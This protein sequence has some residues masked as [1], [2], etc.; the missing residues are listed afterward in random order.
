MEGGG[1]KKQERGEG[2]RWRKKRREQEIEGGRVAGDSGGR[3]GGAR[4][5]GRGR[6][7]TREGGR[8]K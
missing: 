6:W 1:E 8:E 3:L 4:E 5:R 7:R 2:K